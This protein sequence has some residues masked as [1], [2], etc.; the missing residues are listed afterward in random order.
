[1]KKYKIVLI[2]ASFFGFF[3]CKKDATPQG[4]SL[5][6]VF[7]FSPTQERLDN[8]GNASVVKAGNAAQNPVVRKM[9]GHYVEL[10]PSKFTLL[11]EGAVIY[12][13]AELPASNDGYTSCIDFSKAKIAGENETFISV[14]FK[15]IKPGTY[16]YLRISVSYQSGDIKFNINDVPYAGNTYDLTDQT[17]TLNSFLGFNT[18]I[19]TQTVRT[20]SYTE[21]SP[22]T[23]G[24]WAFETGLVSPYSA[25]DI[26]EKGKSPAGAT[27][28]VNPLE[29]F[30]VIIPRGSCIVTGKLDAPLVITGDEAAD[31]KAILSFSINKSFEW[32]DT[33]SNG[34]WDYTYPETI[35]QIVDMGLRGL[36][37]SV[38]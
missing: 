21:N 26:L 25:F 13:G 12:K 37:V 20:K 28:V 8:L 22:Q 29:A 16:E 14:P 27:T 34:K 24:F 35:E 2:V 17:A 36:K 1:M 4:P 15:D 30:G 11:G 10:V 23:Q 19:G 5:N 38:E 9:S 3:S 32:V 18:K 33:N 6:L 31:K 7:K